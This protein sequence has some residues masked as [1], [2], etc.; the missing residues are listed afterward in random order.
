MGRR[1]FKGFIVPRKDPTRDGK[2]R[3][4]P[5]MVEDYF[6]CRAN[7]HDCIECISCLF[8]PKGGRPENERAFKEW[9]AAKGKV[10]YDRD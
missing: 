6:C 8:C 3:G 4:L 7:T 2:L 1:Y 5:D 9:Y 10:E